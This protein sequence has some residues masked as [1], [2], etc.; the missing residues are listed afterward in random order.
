MARNRKSSG[1]TGLRIEGGIFPPDFLSLVAAQEAK[2]QAGNDYGLTR[3]LTL[4]DEL[5]RY[6]RIANDLYAAYV[7]RRERAN[8]NLTKVGVDGWLVPLLKEVFGF[9]DLVP[10]SPKS[11]GESTF[12]ITHCAFDG[13]VPVLLTTRDFDLDRADPRFGDE[14]RRRAPHSCMQELLNASDDTLWGIIANGTRLRFLRDNPSLTRPTYIEADLDLIF[15]EQLYP[16]F[17]ALW[18]LGHASR[19]RPHDCKPASAIIE[20]WRAEAHQTGERALERLREGVTE[21]LRQLG[22]GFLQH[23]ENENLRSALSKGEITPERY[24]QELLRLVYRLLFLFTA[25]ERNLLHAPEA[26]DEQRAIYTQGYSL[27]RLRDRAGKRRHYDRH[28]DLWQGLGI[29]F[30]CLSHGAPAL[31]LPALGG[32]FERTQ[33]ANV[34]SALISNANLLAATRAV[35]NFPTSAGLARVNF[36]DMGTEELGS[37]YESL[38]ELHPRIETETIPWVFSFVGGSGDPDTRG[39]ERKLSGSYY[40]SEPLVQELISSALVPLI[41]RAVRDNRSDPRKALLDLRIID[42]ACGSGHFLLAAARRIA[43]EVARIEAGSDTPDETTR[44]HALREVV[45][46]C[47]YGVDRNPMAVELCRAALWIETIEPGKPLSFLDSHIRCGDSLVGVFDLS[48]LS[49]GI[50]DE[51]YKVLDGDDREVAN[52]YRAKNRREVAEREL[53]EGGFGLARQRDLAQALTALADMPEETVEEI[54]AKRA[55]FEELTAQGAAAWMLE[56]ACDLWTSAFF[57]RKTRGGQFAGPDGLPRRGAETV[58]TSGTVWELLRGREP[59]GPLTGAVAALTGHYRFFHWPLAFAD[60]MARGGFDLVLGNPP[61]E[62]MS[63]DNKE[64]FS[65]YDPVVRAMSKDEQE[66]AFARLLENPIIATK[67]A[68]YCRDLYAAVHFIKSSGRYRLFAPGN[69]GKGDFNV[70]RMFIETALAA[71][72][73]ERVAAQFVPE[74]LYNGANATAIRNELFDN[75]RLT[76]LGGFENTKEIWF[77]RVDS[78][79]KFCLYVA[80]KGGRTEQFAAA[81][82]INTMERLQDFASGQ[83]LSI[84]VSVVAEF[85]PEARAVME[86]AAQSEIDVCAKM[87]GLYPKFGAEVEGLPYRHYMAEVHMGNDRALFS[88]GDEG[89][90]VF[91]GRMIDAYDYRAKGYVCGRGRSAVWE[92]LPFG[93]PSKRIQPQWRILPENIPDKLIGRIDRY[94]IGFGD[95]ASPT[96]QRG[97]CAALI[98]PMT[99]CGDK[100]PTIILSTDDRDHLLWLGVANSLAMDY[101]VRKKVSL[102]MSYTIMDSLPFPRNFLATRASAEIARRVCALCAVGPEMEAFRDSAVEAGILPSVADIV[103]D[104]DHRAVLAAEIDVLVA[105]DVYGLTKDEMLYILDPANILGEDCGIETFKALRNRE[106][107]EFGEY[108]TQK[109]VLEAWDRLVRDEV[110]AP[111]PAIRVAP[112]NPAV[113]NLASLPDGVWARL[114]APQSGETGA[115]LTAILKA[116]GGPHPIRQ[117][118]LAAALVLEPRLL[119][120]LLSDDRAAQWR[121]L[122]G[123]E[124]DPLA[125]NVAAFT[126]RVNAAWGAAVRNHRGNG[127]LI[128]DS[129]MG[130]WTPGS[131]LEAIDTTGWPDGRAAFVLEALRTIDLSRRME[132]LPDD[133][134]RWIADAAAA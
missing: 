24:F 78:R 123:S 77:K 120:P 41:E 54:T 47:I 90:P 42:P 48:V 112:P 125:A 31:G 59:F 108:R 116:M 71:T 74:G 124:A 66:A 105:R 32:L 133:V 114:G 57:A 134:Q 36:R 88:E 50:P 86:F 55:R 17:A 7:E 117:V 22:N 132:T 16:D 56:R 107:R 109:L 104:P 113:V 49:E 70:Y 79:T 30:R 45:Q 111:S 81:F 1:F 99:I 13:T 91:E 27:A 102:K 5:A 61:W 93:L 97:L 11:V 18:L 115:V 15:T 121:R 25:E 119:T 131:G 92:D 26:T 72:R 53:I 85:S 29:L 95:V 38:L 84:P 37:V 10:A 68:E 106:M 96:N 52:H 4:K 129:Q 67:Y 60:V 14:G 3:S 75:F 40:T 82:R 100:V 73:P 89:L 87:Y 23:P 65:T 128:E 63:P 130:T 2:H 6:W 127:R 122:V 51:A 118:R 76:K 58:A 126:I 64:F 12:A 39:S 101:L 43:Y 9:D 80:W 98:P 34:D 44:Q 94:R 46:H 83:T 110:A 21:A 103:E 19:F 20:R 8:L 62:T 33:C 69:L 35:A 28:H